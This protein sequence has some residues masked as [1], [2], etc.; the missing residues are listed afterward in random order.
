MAKQLSAASANEC[1]FV[2]FLS[3]EESKKISKALK[4]PGWVDAIED[5]LNQFTRNKVWTL[6]PAPYG[7]AIIGSKWGFKNKRDET[8]VVIKNKARL[9]TQ[10]YNQQEGIDY[11][12]TFAPVARL[13]VI[14]TFLAFATYKNFIVYQMDVKS[15]FLN[16][17]LKEEVYVKQPSGFESNEFP[18]HVYKLDKA[19]YGLKQA[20]KACEDSNGTPNYLGRDLNGKAVNETQYR[21]NP[22]ESHLIAVKRTFRKS[23]SSACQFLGGK[24]VCWSAKKQ[25]SVA[26]SSAEV[27]YVAAA[28]YCANI[29]WMKRDIE[30]HFIPTQ[31][32]L[33]DI[34]TKPLDEPTFKRLIVELGTNE[35]S[36]AANISKKI[37]LEDLSEFLKDIRSVFFTP[38]SPQDDLIIVT[39]ESEKEEAD[40]DDTHA[41][42]H[43][44]YEDTIVLPPPSSKLAQIQDL[45]AQV[46]LL[47]SQKDELE[48]QKATTEAEITS[49]KAMP[50]YLDINQLITLLVTSL[51]PELSKLL[52][53]HDFASC[54]PTELKELPSKVIELF[55]EIKELKKHVRDMKIKL[56]CILKRFQLNWRHSLSLSLVLHPRFATVVENA[57]KATTKGVPS[58]GHATA[59]PGMGEKNTK[60]AETNLK[61]ELVDLL[62]TNVVTQYYNKKL[63]FDKYCDK[64]LKIKKSPK[65]TNCKV[66]TKKGSITL[67]IYREDGSE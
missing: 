51:K 36:R 66:L 37:K 24:L 45:M 43:N 22:K 63:I 16:C 64:M 55:G 58:A 21:A 20:P 1:L 65:I 49:L 44:V 53:S 41:T 27:E 39:D 57:S 56:P 13:E 34:F 32:Q 62:G 14:M 23:T 38:D 17:K 50:S 35:E 10:G 54:L 42:S 6:V 9:V 31:Y 59:S 29:L 8:G 67:K 15:A 30:L 60:D 33:A 52:A 3:K 12:E 18:N 26:M 2:D 40:K 61:D 47:Q 28:G 4:H 5:E 46:H 25:Q 19:L 7:K 11:D 48:Q